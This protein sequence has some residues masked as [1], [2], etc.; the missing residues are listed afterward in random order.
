MSLSLT[1]HRVWRNDQADP[2][3]DH[4]E[5]GG[6]VVIED[7]DADLRRGTSIVRI[8]RK[9]RLFSPNMPCDVRSIG[10]P[11]KV[12]YAKTSHTKKLER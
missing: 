1:R 5:A 8:E 10:T 12:F 9:K 2:A 3:Y 4:E 11:G 7:V 6:D